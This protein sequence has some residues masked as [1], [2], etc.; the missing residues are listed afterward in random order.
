M[1]NSIISVLGLSLIEEWVCFFFFCFEHLPRK[2]PSNA[3][4]EIF[5]LYLCE[6]KMVS[7][8]KCFCACAIRPILVFWQKQF[9][10][11]KLPCFPPVNEWE[12]TRSLWKCSLL[13]G[14]DVRLP[15]PACAAPWQEFPVVI[16]NPELRLP[17]AYCLL[18][19]PPTRKI[20]FL[21]EI[22]LWKELW[23]GEQVKSFK[24]SRAK[25][26]SGVYRY[27]SLT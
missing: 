27:A 6:R 25:W 11:S 15:D 23:P 17:W 22:I 8:F 21:H 10:Q 24:F 16:L 18:D 19:L 20:A 9:L 12:N 26:I 1:L 7:F 5:T 2:W 3:F 14:D 13:W 4:F